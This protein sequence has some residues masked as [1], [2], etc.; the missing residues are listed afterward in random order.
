M[1]AR[2]ISTHSEGRLSTLTLKPDGAPQK[3][4]AVDAALALRLMSYIGWWAECEMSRTGE[5]RDVMVLR[6][7]MDRQ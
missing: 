1:T 3:T 6:N 2:I 5:I 7:R 4:Y